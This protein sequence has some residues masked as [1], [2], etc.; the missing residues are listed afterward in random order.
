MKPLTTSQEN[1]I[2]KAVKTAVTLV[3]MGATPTEAIEKV[4]R[5]H[6]WGKDM[7]R[8]ASYAYN[9]GK[10]NQQ[11]ESEQDTRSKLAAFSLADSE[12]VIE[13]MWP[14]TVKIAV[15]ASYDF[16]PELI[17][18]NRKA[19]SHPF[20]EKAASEDTPPEI[21]SV[22][23]MDK[24][25]TCRR[26]YEVARQYDYQARRNAKLL[27]DDIGSYFRHS[28]VGRVKF[29][30]FEVCVRENIQGAKSLP[31]LI[32]NT[33]KVADARAVEG[34]VASYNSDSPIYDLT[35]QAIAAARQAKQTGKI[36]VRLSGEL[37]EAV[38]NKD[39]AVLSKTSSWL[40]GAAIGGSIAA[41]KN[42]LNNSL[43]PEAIESGIQ[44]E[45]ANLEDPAHEDE[46]RSI[47]AQ[48]LLA[49]MLED[50]VIGS[51]DP[52]HVLNTYNELSQLAPSAATQPIA[53]RSLLR[54]HLENNVEPFEA[55]EVNKL[56]KD[57]ATQKPNLMSKGAY[58]IL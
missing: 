51:H 24:V 8:F 7:I 25:A 15:E 30:E 47:K 20:F 31:D 16:S 19:S 14:S 53:M 57:L 34:Y 39:S 55:A 49:E 41:T 54:R 37:Q 43:G 40:G 29:A 11:Q 58:A 46:L 45:L 18:R 2:I 27:V 3:D 50:D 33:Y 22:Q 4:A 52:G 12:Q 9:T 32:Y 5:Q 23:L 36:L 26:K 1:K 44:G 42:L 10:Q 17:R 21:D 38:A 13:N 28:P 35:K 56:E 6:K 48:A